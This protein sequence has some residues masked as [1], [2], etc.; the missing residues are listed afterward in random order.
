MKPLCPFRC[1]FSLRCV[2]RFVT[3]MFVIIVFIA[4][5]PDMMPISFNKVLKRC[6]H[7][8]SKKFL[9]NLVRLPTRRLGLLRM[10]RSD[11]TVAYHSIYYGLIQTYFV[12]TIYFT[13]SVL[14]MLSKL[15]LNVVCTL[16]E[17]VQ[18]LYC[19]V[20]HVHCTG[21]CVVL[22]YW[23]LETAINVKI[24]IYLLFTSLVPE[25]LT[26]IGWWSTVP[27]PVHST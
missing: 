9:E 1:C 25:L 22:V 4:W 13:G 15:P 18:S 20:L 2:V 7:A 5:N 12:L 21:P 8:R 16:T 26:G 19:P 6:S 17:V 14:C 24:N 3:V 10:L 23:K 27:C 11:Q